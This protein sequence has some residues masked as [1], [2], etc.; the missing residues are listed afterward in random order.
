MSK[1]INQLKEIAETLGIKGYSIINKNNLIYLIQM[2]YYYGVDENLDNPYYCKHYKLKYTCKEC[3]G[4]QLCRHDKMKYVCKECKGS[5]FCHHN[6][7]KYRCKECG[8]KGIC[9]HGRRKYICKECGWK[10]IC[11]H[12]KQKK[13]QLQRM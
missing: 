1:N 7:Q 6:K 10:G 9:I 8:G 11:S 3:N 2:K 5:S 13:K 12:G 4:S